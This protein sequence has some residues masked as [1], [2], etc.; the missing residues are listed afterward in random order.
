MRQSINNSMFN[1]II[2]FTVDEQ[3]Q[4]IM[5]SEGTIIVCL[6]CIVVIHRL[7]YA[8]E[9]HFYVFIDCRAELPSALDMYWAETLEW[10]WW[11]LLFF[12]E[13]SPAGRT[14][15]LEIGNCICCFSGGHLCV[16]DWS[17]CSWAVRMFKLGS[18]CFF[19]VCE[20]TLSKNC[21]RNWLLMDEESSI[22]FH[23][24]LLFPDQVTRTRCSDSP[25][26]AVAG[27]DVLAG[28]LRM[29]PV[30]TSCCLMQGPVQVRS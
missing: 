18:A 25:E 2:D 6:L 21:L 22:H 1:N 16:R 23:G 29:Q 4:C 8:M 10:V 27:S 26:T 19:K 28:H 5:S 7:S 14:R 9:M 3:W 24:S 20:L 11:R 15:N 13:K 17:R 30:P 12:W